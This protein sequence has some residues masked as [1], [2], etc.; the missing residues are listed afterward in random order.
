MRFKWLGPCHPHR[1]LGLSF[2]E[3]TSGWKIY[4]LNMYNVAVI[5]KQ[6]PTFPKGLENTLLPPKQNIFY[7]K[8]YI[9]FP[10]THKVPEHLKMNFTAHTL[11]NVKDTLS[12][13]TWVFNDIPISTS[14]TSPRSA[15][16]DILQDRPERQF[17]Q[18][19]RKGLTSIS[20]FFPG[21]K[22]MPTNRVT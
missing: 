12:S 10:G 19:Q 6:S 14:D 21:T 1:R 13:S 22:G 7:L 11:Q 2:G 9:K 5:K 4:V 15:H 8:S 3:W 17:V 18:I 16:P 20:L